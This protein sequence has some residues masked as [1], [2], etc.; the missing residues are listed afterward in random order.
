MTPKSRTIASTSSKF[1]YNRLQ[2]LYWKKMQS[3][4]KNLDQ[5][6]IFKVI[7][8]VFTS[9]SIIDPVKALNIQIFGSINVSLVQLD[10][11]YEIKNLNK[12]VAKKDE[13]LIVLF[14]I[15]FLHEKIFY[16]PS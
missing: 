4:T 12:F 3:Q 6:Q 15:P 5:H 8:I 10:G 9:H 14:F 2:A 16:F 11:N 13:W 1:G 7:T